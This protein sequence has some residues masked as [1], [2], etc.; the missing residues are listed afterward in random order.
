V[1]AEIFDEK[2]NLV[3]TLEGSGEVGF[4]S[5][6]WDVK[7]KTVAAPVKGKSKSPTPAIDEM[8]YAGKGKYKLKLTNGSETSEVSFEVK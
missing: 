6:A 4:Q 5:I 7:I 1:K 2:N 8:K 3:R